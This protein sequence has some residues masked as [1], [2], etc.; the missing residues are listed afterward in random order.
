MTKNNV[1]LLVGRD[2]WQKDEALNLT[3]LSRLRKNNVEI[4]WEDPAAE[5]IY[6]LHKVEKKLI[7]LPKFIK[8]FNLRIVQILFCLLHPSYLIYL[9]KRKNKS[10]LSRCE[11]LKKIICKR[12]IAARTI[13]LSRSSGGRVSSLIA[14]E[15]GLKHIVCLGY[16]FKHPDQGDEP[17]RYSHLAHLRT[18]MLIFQGIHDEYGGLEIENKYVLS[19]KVKLF[20]LNTN[21]NFNINETIAHDI[22]EIIGNIANSRSVQHGD[23]TTCRI[24]MKMP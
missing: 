12:G 10:I 1:L 20:F 24:D 22:V 15:L 17:A 9:Y 21:H 8:Q 14:D 16:P 23:V 11:S 4:I 7:F 2:D 6:F 19:D 13:V 5:V 18:P 3:L